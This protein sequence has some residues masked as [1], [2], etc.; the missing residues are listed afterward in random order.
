MLGRVA[1]KR[2]LEMRQVFSKQPSQASRSFSTALNYHLDSPD[3]KKNFPWEFS[4]ANKSKVAK[5]LEVA[6]IR[7][8][9]VA[10]CYSMFNRAKVGKYHLLVCGT[11]PCMIRGL[12]DIES[13]LLEDLGVKRGVQKSQRMVCSLLE[14]YAWDAVC[15]GSAQPSRGPYS[16]L[17]N[18]SFSLYNFF[19]SLKRSKKILGPKQWLI[20]P[21]PGPGLCVLMRS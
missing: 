19:L 15:L 3:N 17:K 20:W 6:P 10:T 8:Y 1:A 16:N 14:R 18:G 4:E 12:R 5:V 9:E 7:V 21:F 13:A 11:T 2:L